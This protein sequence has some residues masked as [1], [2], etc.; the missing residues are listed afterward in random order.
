MGFPTSIASYPDCRDILD[1]ALESSKGLQLTFKTHGEATFNRGRMN[2]FRVRVR[3]ENAHTYPADHPLHKSTPY[4][5]LMI[6]QRGEIV[7][8]EKL[9]VERFNVEELK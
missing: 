2:A 9:I 8:I 4:D 6:K 1:K 5:G 3:R 7:I